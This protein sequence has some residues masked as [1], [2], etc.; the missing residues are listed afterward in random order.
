ML[1]AVAVDDERVSARLLSGKSVFSFPMAC[2][3]GNEG[4]RPF[5]HSIMGQTG[6]MKRPPTGGLGLFVRPSV[7]SLGPRLGG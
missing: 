3:T 1:I 4:E 7:A 6:G 5:L 2:L